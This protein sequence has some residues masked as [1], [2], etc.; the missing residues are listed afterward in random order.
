MDQ[1]LDI[2]LSFPTG[3]FT[4]LVGLSV[5]FWMLVIAGGLGIEFLDFDLDVEAAAQEADQEVTELLSALG[6]GTVPFSI[7]MTVFS[8]LGWTLTYVTSLVLEQYASTNLVVDFAIL[9]GA[10]VASLPLTGA[11]TYPLRQLLETGTDRSGESIVGST[12][13]ISTS[14]VDED[15]G[16]ASVYHE[17]ADLVLSVRCKSEGVLERGDEAL[18]ID[19]DAEEEIYWVEPY[20]DV[21]ERSAAED[22]EV[23]DLAAG[24]VDADEGGESEGDDEEGEE[25]KEAREMRDES[26][27]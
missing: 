27:Q 23:A 16:R 5:I 1:F 21:L 2:V 26:V 8:L 19:W 17:G 22:L 15:F 10:T 7:M 24:D 14:R 12:C 20:E 13:E 18:V 3:V 25:T 4:V 9:L 11:V 6:V